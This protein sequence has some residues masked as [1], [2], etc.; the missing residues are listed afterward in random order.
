MVEGKLYYFEVADM[1]IDK[2][3]NK[4]PAG[5]TV[6]M[7]TEASDGDVTEAV[8]LLCGFEPERLRMITKEEYLKKYGEPEEH[9]ED[10][11]KD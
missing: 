4:H 10:W 9:D 11:E 7:M 1:G 6:G 8:A 3:G 5:L 2:E